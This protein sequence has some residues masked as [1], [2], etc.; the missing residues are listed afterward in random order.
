MIYLQAVAQTLTSMGPQYIVNTYNWVKRALY[1]APFRFY[2]DIELEKQLILRL[3]G[4]ENK[5]IQNH[6]NPRYTT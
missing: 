1:D 5:E 4:E 6:D 3:S 2:L